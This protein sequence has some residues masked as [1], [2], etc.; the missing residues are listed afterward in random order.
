MVKV[1]YVE[2]ESAQRELMTQLLQSQGFE[3]KVAKNGAIGIEKA[4]AWSP[5]VILMDLRMPYMDGFEAIQQLRSTTITADIPIVVIS[6]W[7]TS[8]HE[9]RALELGANQV[10]TKPYDLDEIV[11]V[12]LAHIKG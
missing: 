6:A 3:V 4:R 7:T 5:D 9:K 8:R 10:I 11:S 2:D 1:L 12:V